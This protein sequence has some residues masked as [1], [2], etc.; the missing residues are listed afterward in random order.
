MQRTTIAQ[1]DLNEHLPRANGAGL[2]ARIDLRRRALETKLSQY[3][4]APAPGDRLLPLCGTLITERS[5]HSS[6][7]RV[8]LH[9]DQTVEFRLPPLTDQESDADT[10]WHLR[11]GAAAPHRVTVGIVDTGINDHHPELAAARRDGNLYI[12]DSPDDSRLTEHGTR[13]ASLACGMTLGLAPELR[14]YFEGIAE[15]APQADRGMIRLS[16]LLIA[17]ERLAQQGCVII[18]MSLALGPLAVANAAI[19]RLTA[20]LGVLLVCSWAGNR[21][22]PAASAAVLRVLSGDGPGRSYPA[23]SAERCPQAPTTRLPRSVHA[24][25]FGHLVATGHQGIRQD[26]GVSYAT[27]AV[28]LCA[29]RLLAT[30]PLLARQPARLRR[31]VIERACFRAVHRSYLDAFLAPVVSP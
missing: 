10:R 15:P 22:E 16:R 30:E 21:N 20:E 29:A 31:A 3:G 9:A 26:S 27:L 6:N 1:L 24:P 12:N 28:S 8:A 23:T 4:T 13:I 25:G 14:L 2:S 18:N 11:T 7:P 19:N 17:L 5:V